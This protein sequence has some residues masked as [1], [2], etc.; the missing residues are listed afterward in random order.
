MSGEVSHHA[1]VEALRVTL[2]YPTDDTQGASRLDSSDSPHRRLVCALDEQPRFLTNISGEEGRVRV[3][4][5]AL[6]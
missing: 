4:V 6:R 2:D 1:V 3:A 5:D